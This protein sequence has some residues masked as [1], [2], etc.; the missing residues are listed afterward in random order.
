MTDQGY[1]AQDKRPRVTRTHCLTRRLEYVACDR[2]AWIDRM[3]EACGHTVTGAVLSAWCK[4]VFGLP[5]RS[6]RD[7]VAQCPHLLLYTH[8]THSNSQIYVGE[9]PLPLPWVDA[10]H[11]CLQGS[12]LASQAHQTAK[13]AGAMYE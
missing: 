13:R 8:L 5:R 11:P 4:C 2:E 9:M 3:N 7:I 12:Y 1:H 6:S 10:A